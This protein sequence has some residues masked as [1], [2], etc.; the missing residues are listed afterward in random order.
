[1]NPELLTPAVPTDVPELLKQN[2]LKMKEIYDRTAS[3]KP[4]PVLK[5]NE[6]VQMR[7]PKDKFWSPAIVLD[8]H[9]NPRSYVVQT[10]DGRVYQ[11]NR[12]DLIKTP[13]DPIKPSVPLEDENFSSNQI[14]TQSMSQPPP[15]VENPVVQQP[16]ID[17]PI[18]RRSTRVT[19]Q[20]DRLTYS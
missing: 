20:P 11:R 16:V 2:Q 15:I 12:R 10:E 6:S 19:R 13:L 1:M 3:R 7:K 9:P 8:K 17:P 4:L 18:L 5:A 14:P